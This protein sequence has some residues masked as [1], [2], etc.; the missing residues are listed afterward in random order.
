MSEDDGKTH[1]MQV[2]YVLE[3]VCLGHVNHK[4][5]LV[6]PTYWTPPQEDKPADKPATEAGQAGDN[7]PHDHS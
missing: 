5:K 4:G 7:K 6:P 3:P 1:K 2:Q